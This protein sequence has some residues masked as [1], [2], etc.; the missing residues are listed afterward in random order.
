MNLNRIQIIGNLTRDPEGRSTQSGARVVN[1]TVAVNEKYGQREDTIFLKVEAWNKT[2]EIAERFL[3][4]GSMVY[5]EGRLKLDEYEAR[6]GQKR[7]DP[8]VVANNIVLGP[9]GRGGEGGGGYDDDRGGRSDYRDE[10]PR[11]DSYQ[12]EEAPSRKH[13]EYNQE[14]NQ[15]SAPSGQGDSTEDDLPF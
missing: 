3:R 8:V 2:G 4:K 6:D 13:D 7:R 9:K 12:R 5:V 14:H 1:F 11:R 10:E 15:P